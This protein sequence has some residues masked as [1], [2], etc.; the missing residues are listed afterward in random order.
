MHLLA[1][2]TSYTLLGVLTY[3]Y[4]SCKARNRYFL[5]KPQQLSGIGT[6]IA[7]VLQ[8]K[9]VRNKEFIIFARD[10]ASKGWGQDLNP[11]SLDRKPTAFTFQVLPHGY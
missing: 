8:M 9:K 4:T 7:L 1:I 5:F 11:G 6:F 10:H 2:Y 3:I